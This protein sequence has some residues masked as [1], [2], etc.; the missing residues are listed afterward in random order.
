MS[1][2]GVEGKGIIGLCRGLG[3]EIRAS[4]EIAPN[5]L[6]DAPPTTYEKCW[7]SN[8][9]GERFWRV[10]ESDGSVTRLLGSYALWRTLAGQ[11]QLTPITRMLVLR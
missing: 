1:E 5:A 8:E 10:L 4:V 2:C 6:E 3:G 11:I 7:G 9:H